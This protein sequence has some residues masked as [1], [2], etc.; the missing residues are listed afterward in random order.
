[1]EE[2]TEYDTELYA[3][4]MGSVRVIDETNQTYLICYGGGNY[5][6][7]SVEEID[8]S[9]GETKFKFTFVFNRKM[10]NANKMR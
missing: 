3:N 5:K 10:Y 4:M 2:Y 8:Y 7:Y 9:T 6:K 1:M